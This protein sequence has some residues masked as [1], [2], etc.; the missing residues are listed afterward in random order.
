MGGRERQPEQRAHL[1]PKGACHRGPGAGGVQLHPYALRELPDRGAPGR[2]VAG[3]PEQRFRAVRG[4]QLG[5]P[6]VA[7]SGAGAG[8]RPCS[9]PQPAAASPGVPVR[10]VGGRAVGARVG[11]Q[12]TGE[13]PAVMRIWPGVPYPQGAT[14]DGQGVNFSLFSENATGVEL[15]LFD[16]HDDSVESQRIPIRERT[17]LIWHCYLPDARP[18]QLYGYRV[19]GPYEP[20]QGHRFNSHKL[21]IDPYAKA[22][23]GTI[24]WS[25]ALYGYPIGDTEQDLLIDTR[26]SAGETPK[27]VVV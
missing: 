9:R 26:D 24:R 22:I 14:W 21:L 19:H 15:C 11:S 5:Q 2:D 17:D 12:G 3:G 10:Q 20:E 8:A 23:S 6:G 13:R 4:E 16:H 7:R 25:D 1:P 27:S 18:G